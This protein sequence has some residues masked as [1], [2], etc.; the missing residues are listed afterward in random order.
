MDLVGRK[1]ALKGGRLI[2]RLFQTLNGYLQ[3]NP[4]A[5]HRDELAGAVRALE[6]ATNWI[7]TNGMQDPEQAGSAATPY[8]RLM[9][10]TV[11]AWLWSRKALEA[12][13]QLDAGEGNTALMTAKLVTCRFYFEKIL[14]EIGGLSADIA[15]GKESVMGLAD[16]Q[17]QA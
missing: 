12:Q 3:D 7:A 8:L 5:P 6:E 10:L 4:A 9:A 14:P 11:I 17:W 16:L 15:S 13:R 2:G 1:L